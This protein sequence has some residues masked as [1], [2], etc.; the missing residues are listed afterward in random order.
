MRILVINGSPKGEWSTTLQTSKYL[1]KVFP[2][3]GF[4]YLN[5]ASKIKWYEKDF[6][7]ARQKIDDAELIIFSYPVYTFFVPAQFARFLELIAKNGVDLT[8]KIITQITTSKHFYDVTAHEFIR[9][10]VLDSGAKYIR[11]LSQ[12]M[13]D[14]STEKG[15][16]QAKD[17]FRSLLFSVEKGLFDRQKP[18]DTAY[19]PCR[20]T[21]CSDQKAEK[22]NKNQVVIVTDSQPESTLEKMVGRF[23]Q[24][25]PFPTTVVNIR[26]FPF[27][28]GCLGC[29]RCATSGKCVYTDRFDDFLRQ[30]IQSADA[31]LYA[32]TIQN[33]AMGS[34]FKT[35]DDR[36]FCNG[37][38]TVTSGKPTGYIV[39]G[40][41]SAEQNLHT[42]LLAR[43]EVGG[44]YLCGVCGD[45]NDFEGELHD[46]I[47]NLTFA[48]DTHVSRPADF[49]GTGGTKIFR[50]LI[51][52]MQGI[53]RADHAFYKKNGFYDDMP[54]KKRG[55]M[56]K[57]YFVGALMKLLKNPKI[58]KKVSGNIIFEG[59]LLPYKKVID[60]AHSEE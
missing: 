31:I 24:S 39:E 2:S 14:L 42:V 49:Y 20:I 59:M 44:N 3:H 13:G 45:E 55:S 36:Q 41:L 51:Y 23:V 48:L 8:Q 30:K 11:G 29:L 10:N 1:E 37:H 25:A 56:I 22:T 27:R 21:D 17:F 43:S 6:S 50:D 53:M 4:T 12:D 5:A 40:K 60:E 54:H 58:A 18:I 7:E 57:F 15:Q 19:V 28:G 33:H 52:E 35:Y 34:L 16:K 46:L 38:R 9:Q 32:F 47:E 26:D